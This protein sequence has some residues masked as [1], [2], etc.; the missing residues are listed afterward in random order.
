MNNKIHPYLKPL[1]HDLKEYEIGYFLASSDFERACIECGG[2]IA[3]T[4]DVF[5]QEAIG[6]RKFVSIDFDHKIYDS[7]NAFICLLEWAIRLEDKQHNLDNWLS[8]ILTG[9][10]GWSKKELFFDDVFK[11]L[12]LLILDKDRLIDIQDCYKTHKLKFSKAH[13]KRNSSNLKTKIQSSIS[14]TEKKK[15]WIILISEAK[16]ENTI[17]EIR[18]IAIKQNKEEWI[19]SIVNISSRWYLLQEQ[20][21]KGIGNQ[22]DISI[23]LNKINESLLN[24]IRNLND[25]EE[26]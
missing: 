26:V 18:D 9:F 6:N 2:G 17:K 25:T 19:S 7:E 10:M 5:Y 8:F 12:E 20:I 16:H 3:N 4:W 24:F 21:H 1:I 15:D 23:E 14:F 11:D 13:K 22:I